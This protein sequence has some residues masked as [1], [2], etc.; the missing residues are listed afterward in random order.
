MWDSSA[1]LD[2][3]SD[4]FCTNIIKTHCLPVFCLYVRHWC[5][6]RLSDELPCLFMIISPLAIEAL[7]HWWCTGICD[8][9]S[10]FEVFPTKEIKNQLLSSLLV[11]NLSAPLS[12]CTP[13]LLGSSNYIKIAFCFKIW[14]PDRC[15]NDPVNYAFLSIVVWAWPNNPLLLAPGSLYC[16]SMT[17]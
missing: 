3:S 17:A 8:I 16:F 12:L 5:I 14:F 7:L 2:W 11:L 6:K 1:F 10:S 13:S 15:S 4:F 9:H